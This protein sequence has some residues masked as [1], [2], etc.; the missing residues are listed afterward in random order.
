M[1][2]FDILEEK[3]TPQTS[4]VLRRW[5]FVKEQVLLHRLTTRVYKVNYLVVGTLSSSLVLLNI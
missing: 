5:D 3:K 2:V 1:A 4:A